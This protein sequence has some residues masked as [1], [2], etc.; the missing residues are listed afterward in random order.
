MSHR[1]KLTT[2]VEKSVEKPTICLKIP[3][4][5]I[6]KQFVLHKENLLP[7]TPK[8]LNSRTFT[9][10]FLSNL[11]IAEDL[12]SAAKVSN[13][14]EE[15]TEFLTVEIEVKNQESRY[16]PDYNIIYFNIAMRRMMDEFLLERVIDRHGL[17]IR[18]QDT[19]ADFIEDYGLSDLCTV[20]GLRRALQRLE[21]I[22]GVPTIKK[23]QIRYGNKL[24]YPKKKTK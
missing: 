16:I 19:I 13:T 24:Y 23:R 5:K 3:V 20:D 14:V 8:R 4:S 22:K 2:I 17:G 21:E 7:D 10:L 11:L 1:N 6:V 9:A 18:Q 12:F 15:Y